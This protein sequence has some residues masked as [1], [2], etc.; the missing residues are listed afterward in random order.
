MLV[1]CVKEKYQ[2]S[3]R[4]AKDNCFHIHKPDQILVFCKAT[5][6]LYYFDTGDCMEY[7]GVLATTVEENK[8]RFL[9]YDYSQAKLAHSIYICIGQPSLA[10][11][12]YYVANNLIT[13]YPIVTQD[14]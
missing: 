5:R 12:Y 11:Y 14:I 8:A 2:I 13:N 9:A 10:N 7:S 1:I 4:S 3:F 6:R